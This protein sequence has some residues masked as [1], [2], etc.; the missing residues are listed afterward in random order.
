MNPYV[1]LT[2]TILYWILYPLY[3][4]AYFLIQAVLAIILFFVHPVYSVIL[5]LIQPA[6]FVGV[7]LSQ[8]AVLPIDLIK[9]FETIY[10]YL[11]V[12]GLVGITAGL[13]IHT[14]FAFLV[15]SLGLRPSRAGGGPTAKE[16]RQARRRK[17]EKLS[18]SAPAEPTVERSDTTVQQEKPIKQDRM[19]LSA[20]PKLTLQGPSP[21]GKRSLY[22]QTMAGDADSD[23]F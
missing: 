13:L 3:W 8:L 19:K 16:H 11:G 2:L 17:A 21:E 4:I 7:F 15:S 20:L 10:I 22:E 14:L 9:R 18:L 5:F 1:A 12:G 23:G 6:I